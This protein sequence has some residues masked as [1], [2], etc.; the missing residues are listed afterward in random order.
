MPQDTPGTGSARQGT[1]SGGKASEVGDSQISMLHTWDPAVSSPDPAPFSVEAGSPEKEHK[2]MTD[3]NFT[4]DNR[5]LSVGWK[6]SLD[7]LSQ[8]V[9][10]DSSGDYAMHSTIPKIR[11][12][13]SQFGR[14]LEPLTCWAQVWSVSP[15]LG[16]LA[17]SRY[18]C[19][20]LHS[21]I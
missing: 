3:M 5:R 4:N 15:G 21:K 10:E 20:N 18:A 7:C 14:L 1:A 13:S 12:S 16:G 19:T 8:S 11:Q 9:I 6:E 2:P 17:T